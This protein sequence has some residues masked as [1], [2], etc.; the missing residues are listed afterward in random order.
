[1]PTLEVKDVVSLLRAEVRRAGGVAAWCKKTGVH[2]SVVSRVLHNCPPTKSMIKA[3]NL[4]T[5]FVVRGN[6]L[7]ATKAKRR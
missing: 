7:K 6:Q 4:R 2:R 5:V 3:L 1:L